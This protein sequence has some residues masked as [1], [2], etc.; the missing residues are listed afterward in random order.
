MITSD[1]FDSITDNNYLS[2]APP[3]TFAEVNIFPLVYIY[4]F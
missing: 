2:S 3:K 4:Y 1:I